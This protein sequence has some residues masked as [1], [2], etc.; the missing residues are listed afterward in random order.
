MRHHLAA[1]LVAGIAALSAPAAAAPLV[2]NEAVDGALGYGEEVGSL[3]VGI[4][5]VTGRRAQGV[6]EAFRVK[7]AEG[8][9]I[10]SASMTVSNFTAPDPAWFDGVATLN[11]WED[12][13]ERAVS[14]LIRADGTY[15]AFS[16]A[17][18]G[19]VVLDAL[20][21]GFIIP[22]GSH[23]VSYNDAVSF[24][25]AVTPEPNAVPEPFG[26]ALFGAGLAGLIVARRRKA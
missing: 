25:V 5:T 19:P 15:E 23:G 11:L 14:E 12:G 8:L 16:G 24:T 13:T 6:N 1:A 2:Y 21:L 10:T 3:G 20:V 26:L 17:W 9:R 22:F 4:N 18:D 7:L